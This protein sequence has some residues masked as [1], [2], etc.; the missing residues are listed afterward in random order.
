MEGY[1]VAVVVAKIEQV[2][3]GADAEDAPDI[4]DVLATQSDEE[5]ADVR[6]AV[7]EVLHL[8]KAEGDIEVG[9]VGIVNFAV[10]V[11]GLEVEQLLQVF[12]Y[13]S[14]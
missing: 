8:G 9:A 6:L 1:V 10:V 7:D 12:M 14:S 13:N 11:V 5:D 4:D 3:G 2:L